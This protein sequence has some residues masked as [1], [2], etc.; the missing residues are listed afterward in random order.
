VVHSIEID[1]YLYRIE[2]DAIINNKATNTL[3]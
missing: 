3:R 1:I 2:Y